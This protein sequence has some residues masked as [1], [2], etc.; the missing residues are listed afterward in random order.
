[1]GITIRTGCCGGADDGEPLAEAAVEAASAASAAESAA[2]AAEAA[3]VSAELAAFVAEAAASSAAVLAAAK[4]SAPEEG[5]ET[6]AAA[7]GPAEPLLKLSP[8]KSG[9]G[10]VSVSSTPKLLKLKPRSSHWAKHTEAEIRVKMTQKRQKTI[11][12]FMAT[13][14]SYLN[15]ILYFPQ[16]CKF[17]ASNNT[18]YSM[19]IFRLQFMKKMI[20]YKS[21]KIKKER[22]NGRKST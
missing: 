11:I 3:A 4:S 20:Y 19:I 1:M 21:L 5:A 7:G 13:L 17:G 6:G 2:F 10:S 15:S 12:F 9:S 8:Y 18:L 16:N 14:H 22:N